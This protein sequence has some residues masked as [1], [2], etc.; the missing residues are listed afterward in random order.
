MMKKSI[1]YRGNA[2]CNCD[3][4]E[5]TFPECD[6]IRQANELQKQYNFTMTIHYE[7]DLFEHK[8][9]IDTFKPLPFFLKHLQDCAEQCR[10]VQ[11]KTK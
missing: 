9:K 6:V 11:E 3:F 10:K 8:T 4:C 7:S 5:K 1:C 2:V